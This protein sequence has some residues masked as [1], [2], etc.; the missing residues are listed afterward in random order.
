MYVWNQ[1]TQWP[2][3]GGTIWFDAKKGS[4]GSTGDLGFSST[5]GKI[6]PHG[7]DWLAKIKAAP[8]G[9]VCVTDN[10]LMFEAPEGG[11]QSEWSKD[12][13]GQSEHFTPSY[14]IKLYV[15]MPDGN[16][17]AIKAQFYQTRVGD[18]DVNILAYVSQSSSRNLQYDQEKRINPRH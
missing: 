6:Y 7:Y 15:R 2:K 11:Y 5:V 3:D 16:F 12:F 17:A 8:P 18:G 14:S 9:G 1:V 13:S 10:E 4:F